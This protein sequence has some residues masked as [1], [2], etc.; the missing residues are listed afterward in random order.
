MIIAEFLSWGAV[1]TSLGLLLATWTPRIG[2][3]IGSSVA[4]FLLLSFGS[5]LVVAIAIIPALHRWL[6]VRYNIADVDLIWLDLGLMAASPIFAPIATIQTLEI[7]YA[8]RL[9]FWAILSFWCLL[10]CASAAAMFWAAVRSFDHS[11]GRMPETS[12]KLTAHQM[13]SLVPVDAG[14][15]AETISR[16]L[17]RQRI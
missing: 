8:G 15:Q 17:A 10:A 4:A 16:A 7:P 9:M 5:I 1:F 14:C 2:R 6:F 13:P 11:L 12:P 3:A